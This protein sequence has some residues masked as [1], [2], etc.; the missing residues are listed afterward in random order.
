MGSQY[1]EHLGE[2]VGSTRLRSLYRNTFLYLY[3][4]TYLH[5]Y[6]DKCSIYISLKVPVLQK[7]ALK[8]FYI[9]MSQ[10]LAN[11]GGLQALRETAISPHQKVGFV[12]PNLPKVPWIS[13]PWIQ[14]RT[15]DEEGVLQHRSPPSFCFHFYSYPPFANCSPGL[16]HEKHTVFAERPGWGEC[17]NK[18]V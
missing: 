8:K 5:I 7:L 12:P 2:W 6:T 13:V 11:F 4:W 10:C 18:K 15:W 3:I 17:L 16:P 1:H 14:R 9:N